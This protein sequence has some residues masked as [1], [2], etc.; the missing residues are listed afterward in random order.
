[1]SKSKKDAPF[2]QPGELMI[3]TSELLKDK[4][5]LKIYA[6]IGIPFYWLRKFLYGEF[7]NPSVNRVEY[8]YRHLSGK[9]S[10]HLLN[11]KTT[12]AK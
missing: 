12:N 6:E 9:R 3:R 7:K 4:D 1:M 5:L 11:K 2:D 8:L 10:S